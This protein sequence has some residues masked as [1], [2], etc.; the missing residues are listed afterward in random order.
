MG[1][2]AFYKELPHATEMS[3][4]GPIA[5]SPLFQMVCSL[6]GYVSCRQSLSL[7]AVPSI[8]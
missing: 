8:D 1:T 6:E 4:S 2:T 3:P 5:G 7:H